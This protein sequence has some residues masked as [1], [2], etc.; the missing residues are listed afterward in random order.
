VPGYE[1]LREL[2][3]GGMGV[4][5]LARQVGLRRLVALKMIL[6]GGHAGEAARARFRTEAEAVARLQDPHI[7]TVHEVGEHQG[8]PYLCL[9]YVEG[10]SLARR[11]DGTPLPARPAAQ[12]VEALARAADYAHR[13]GVVHR[14]LKPA[15][16]LLAADGTPK[17][18]DF[19]LAK[20]LDEADG[21]TGTGDVMG[22]PSYMAPEQTGQHGHPVGP[23]TDVYALGAI[24]YELLT[25]RPPFKGATALDT[26]FQVA[27]QEPVPPRRLQPGVPRDLETVCLKCL[28]KEPAKRYAS[29]G[30]L[31]DDLDRFLQDRP[32]LARPAG[33]LES[34][35]RWCRRSPK[36]AGLAAALAVALAAGFAAVTGLWLRADE[37]RAR[38]RAHEVGAEEQRRQAEANYRLALQAVDDYCTKVAND[39]RLREKDL[40]PL[41]KELL[42]TAVGFY[43]KFVTER[44][45]DRQVRAELG[46]A[47]IRLASL[48]SD[49]G[50]KEK[51]IRFYGQALAVWDELAHEQ[52][53]CP[54]YR[55]RQA[56]C[57]DNLALLYRDT[58][59]PAEA[60]ESH[61]R[62]LRIL[63]ALVQDHGNV[64]EYQ[65]SLASS[66]NGLGNLYSRTGR[67]DDAGTA[68]GKALTIRKKLT[69]DHA[70]VASYQANLATVQSNLGILYRRTGRRDE[71]KTAYLEAIRTLESVAP[72]VP[73][74][75]KYQAQLAATYLNLGNVYKDGRQTDKAE[76]AFWKAEDIADR[77][78][79]GHPAVDDYQ[80]LLATARNGLGNTY[81]AVGRLPQ[82]EAAFKKAL[83]VA[84]PLARKRPQVSKYTVLVGGLYCN[85]GDLARELK[86]YQDGLV[87]LDQAIQTLQPEARPVHRN[88]TAKRYLRNAHFDRA[89]IW[90]AIGKQAEALKD[91]DRALQ[92]EPQPGRAKTRSQRAVV[93]AR[94]GLYRRAV[95]EVMALKATRPDPDDWVPFH[96]ACVYSRASAWVRQDATL[97]SADRDKLAEDYADRALAWLGRARAAGFFNDP[98]NAEDLKQEMDLDPLRPRPAFQKLLAEVAKPAKPA[99][100]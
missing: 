10:G 26:V 91:L 66:Y 61:R 60:E 96:A 79:R 20:L 97:S 54:Y 3:R 67:L 100:K 40:E 12:L 85:L 17:I 73:A 25:G 83:E 36:V 84:R 46:R 2:G 18:T 37:Q 76:A 4:V 16:V 38:A 98:A 69:T 55:D 80:D 22:T 56:N 8:L 33:K 63:E 14:D 62:A 99:G 19:G 47:Y 44:S 11:L 42:Q 70:D 35:W 13:R 24:L 81:S 59:R 58:R 39:P 71:A 30:G 15:N 78:A 94:Q 48:T 27:H 6:A 45:A 92:L 5:Y 21:P 49:I 34:L 77:L 29:A 86:K 41:R 53:E 65:D 50:D 68:Y 89:L 1:V 23:A 64:A 75:A 28:A 52:L 87:W 88:A 43:Q 7:V 9:E 32:T 90:T 72:D 74:P 31:A 51:A 93:L 82:A 95:D 57:H